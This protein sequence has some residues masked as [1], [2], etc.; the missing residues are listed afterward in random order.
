MVGHKS[1]NETIQRFVTAAL[2]SLIP[3]SPDSQFVLCCLHQ[4]RYICDISTP[5]PHQRRAL[6]ATIPHFNVVGSC[7]IAVDIH[8]HNRDADICSIRLR[9]EVNAFCIERVGI[10]VQ[11]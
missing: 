8:V 5:A 3:P 6:R 11:W 10:G 9:Y 4:I 7:Y 2:V 1:V